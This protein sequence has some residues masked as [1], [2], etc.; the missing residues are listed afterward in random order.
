MNKHASVALSIEVLVFEKVQSYNLFFGYSTPNHNTLAVENDWLPS[1]G[2]SVPQIYRFCMFT[3]PFR[4][5]IDLSEEK[6]FVRYS[7]YPLG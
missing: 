3:E 4:R 7:E 1:V 6:I 2:R 5:K